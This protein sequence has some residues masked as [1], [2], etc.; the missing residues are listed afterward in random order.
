MARL[1]KEN[2]KE[3]AES[4]GYVLEGHS[5]YGGYTLNGV[6]WVEYY[7]IGSGSKGYGLHTLKAVMQCINEGHL[8]N[9]QSE[10]FINK[11]LKHNEI[12]A[13]F[14][15]AYLIYAKNPSKYPEPNI[16]NYGLEVDKGFCTNHLNRIVVASSNKNGGFNS[17]EVYPKVYSYC[18]EHLTDDDTQVEGFTSEPKDDRCACY[19]K[20]Q[21]ETVNCNQCNLAK[22]R[23]EINVKKVLANRPG[24]TLVATFNLPLDSKGRLLTRVDLDPTF[25]SKKEDLRRKYPGAWYEGTMHTQIRFYAYLSKEQRQNIN[26][27]N[28]PSNNPPGSEEI[29][30]ARIKCIYP[31]CEPNC[32]YD[33]EQD[34]SIGK[35]K[36]GVNPQINKLNVK[37]TRDED[38]DYS[39]S[40]LDKPANRASYEVPLLNACMAITEKPK[41]IQDVIEEYNNLPLLVSYMP[42][43]ADYSE[44]FERVSNLGRYILGYFKECGKGSPGITELMKSYQRHQITENNFIEWALKVISCHSSKTPDQ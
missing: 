33:C 25:A 19:A 35:D 40:V 1:T 12:I 5:R 28:N 13:M 17:S 11:N 18:R 20:P 42:K 2:V 43:Y 26:N 39:Y 22:H 32:N 21:S 24:K 44:V 8:L 23:R 3:Y 29:K 6:D 15:R 30:A 41:T 27:V 34:A 38:R 9:G 37:Q 36:E 16:A 14:C 31:K 10:S 4:C 7:K